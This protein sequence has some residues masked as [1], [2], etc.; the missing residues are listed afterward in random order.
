MISGINLRHLG[1]DLCI[2]RQKKRF[3]MFR[4]PNLGTLN[5]P[6]SMQLIGLITHPKVEGKIMVPPESL[7]QYL[8]N[9]YR[10]QCN[11]VSIQIFFA[12]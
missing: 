12:F 11:G 9:K 6:G 1:A 10:Y 4:G 5:G 2:L 3:S 7:S 8:S